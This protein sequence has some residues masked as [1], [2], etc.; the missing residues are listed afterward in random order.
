[1]KHR[2]LCAALA[3][4]LLMTPAYAESLS[5]TREGNELNITWTAE[6]ECT[7]TVYKNNWPVQVCAVRGSDGGARVPVDGGSY[8]VRLR[9]SNGCLTAKAEDGTAKPT[10]QP[11]AKPTAEPTAKSTVAPTIQPTVKPTAVPTAEPTA[12]PASSDL[13]AQVIDEVNAERAKYGLSA[14][15]ADA[16]LTRAACVR[17]NEI[18]Q[19]FSHT[20]PNG[21]SWSTVSG[22][23]RG[24]NIAKGHSSVARVMAAWMSSEGHRANILRESFGSVGVCVIDVGGVRYWAQLFGK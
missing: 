18:V 19:S 24:E 7:L 22:A 10:T 5:A 14:L 12:K 21:E 4:L 23:A 2:I 17:A 16:E 6:G 13:A 9:T 3:I 8:S 11:T 15:K 20:R 1:M